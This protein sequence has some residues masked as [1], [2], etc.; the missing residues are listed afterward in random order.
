M[1]IIS[2]GDRNKVYRV[3]CPHCGSIIQAEAWEFHHFEGMDDEPLVE[4]NQPC[5][6]CNRFFSML[7]WNFEKCYVGEGL[8]PDEKE[9]MGLYGGDGTLKKEKSCF[10]RIKE[11]FS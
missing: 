6:N 1:K 11:W 10:D 9:E 8:Y 2:K 5:P 4:P 3:K 7:K